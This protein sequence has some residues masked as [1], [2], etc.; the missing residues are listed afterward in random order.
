[1]GSQAASVDSTIAS[2]TR[3]GDSAEGCL[4]LVFTVLGR[5]R[6][7][8]WAVAESVRARGEG[9]AE[10][11][12]VEEV[13]LEV[14]AVQ[15]EKAL[16]LRPCRRGEGGRRSSGERFS[17]RRSGPAGQGSADAG[18]RVSSDSSR[19]KR[20]LRVDLFI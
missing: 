11:T 4:M 7:I 2:N 14:F 5:V 8:A 16:G 13:R 20:A 3:W 12:A 1:M 9:R 15:H 6:S 10:R 17:S 18:E 19:A